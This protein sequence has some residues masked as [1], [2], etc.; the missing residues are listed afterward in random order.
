LTAVVSC[1]LGW[2]HICSARRFDSGSIAYAASHRDRFLAVPVAR[3]FLFV[4]NGY[5]QKFRIEQI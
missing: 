1:G 3:A 4:S 5:I 2:R